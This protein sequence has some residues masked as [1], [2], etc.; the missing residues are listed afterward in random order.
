MIEESALQLSTQ[1][2]TDEPVEETAQTQ[3]E[4]A[5][6]VPAGRLDSELQSS[7][8]WIYRSDSKAGTI[9]IMLL[10]HGGFDERVYYDYVDYLE[11][12][13]VEPSALKI[14][15]TRTRG[16]KVYSVVYGE[17]ESWKAAGNAIEKLPKVLRDASPI[18]RSA[19]GLLEEIER[20]QDDN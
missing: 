4:K 15:V 11:T 19:G 16:K 9:Q 2:A 7:L 12:Q 8:D 13:G 17:Y 10:A 1:A 5:A 20:L 14:F 6:A 18:P 3:P